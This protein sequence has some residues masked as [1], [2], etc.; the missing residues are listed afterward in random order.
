MERLSGRRA[1]LER[2]SLL[3]SHEE[4]KDQ[5]FEQILN[6]CGRSIEWR[7]RLASGW[8]SAVWR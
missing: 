4:R 7:L 6:I 5:R 2:L 3:K 1:R 8:I